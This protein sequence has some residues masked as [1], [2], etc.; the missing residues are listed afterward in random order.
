MKSN[1]KP[2]L[3]LG[4]LALLIVLAFTNFTFGNAESFLSGASKELLASTAVLTEIETVTIP[5]AENIPFLKNWS[6]TYE[7]DFDRLLNYLEIANILVLLQYSLLKISHWVV[8]KWLMVA[9]FLGTLWPASRKT[10]FRLLVLFLMISP[11]LAIYSSLTSGIVKQTKLDLGQDLKSHLVSTKDSLNRKKI[12]QQKKLDQLKATQTSKHDG[13]LT[14]VDKV[15]DKT[16]QITNN[17]DDDADMIGSDIVDILRFAGH[18]AVQLAMDMLVNVIIIFLVLP[19]LFWYIFAIMLRNL[20]KFDIPEELVNVQNNK[21][22]DVL[23]SLIKK[24]QS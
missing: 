5:L 2:I 10:A 9:T 17:I 4:G 24:K 18:H 16:I 7:N 19:F 1:H 6:Y 23:S 12:L 3:I 14:F 8:F 15:E 11:G 21:I 13:K 20:F 22:S